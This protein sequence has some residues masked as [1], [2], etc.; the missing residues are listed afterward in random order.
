MAGH[1]SHFIDNIEHSTGALGHGLSVGL[2]MA[3]VAFLKKLT[4]EFMLF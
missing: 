4:I 3:I 1:A 2:G